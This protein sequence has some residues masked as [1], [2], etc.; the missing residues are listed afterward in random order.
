[1]KKI[2]HLSVWELFIFMPLGEW[3]TLECTQSFGEEEFEKA[4]FVFTMKKLNVKRT[5][6]KVDA[7]KR[8]KWPQLGVNRY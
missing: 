1:M 3:T 8:S 2:S 6:T 5:L 4:K 7:V